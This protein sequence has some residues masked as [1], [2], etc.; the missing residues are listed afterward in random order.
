VD[1]EKDARN[2]RRRR[3][4]AVLRLW[5]A[6]NPIKTIKLQFFLLTN[7]L[8]VPA[9]GALASGSSPLAAALTALMAAALNVIWLSSIGRTVAFQR[10]WKREMEK[11]CAED[12]EDPFLRLHAPEEGTLPFWGCV[13][14]SRYLI[15]APLGFAAIWTV[16]LAWAVFLH[17]GR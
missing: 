17:A 10:I 12:R 9:Y 14:S 13:S 5:E 16:L 8:L 2:D 7:G 15:G 4:E 11:L 3:Y 6:E 1:G